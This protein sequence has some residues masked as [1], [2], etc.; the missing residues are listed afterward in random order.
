MI[1]VP[2]GVLPGILF[3][4]VKKDPHHRRGSIF[5]PGGDLIPTGQTLTAAASAP[6]TASTPDN[7]DRQ[8]ITRSAGAP[9]I[10]LLPQHD[11][12]LQPTAKSGRRR[13]RVSTAV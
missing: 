5:V 8:S 1:Y 2:A 7:G 6:E 9:R 12:Y 3:P 11:A 13:A 10:C 4:L